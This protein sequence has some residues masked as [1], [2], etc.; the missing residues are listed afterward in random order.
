MRV[1]IFHRVVCLDAQKHLVHAA[2]LFLQIVAVVR[3]YQRDAR[4]PGKTDNAAD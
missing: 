1:G 4:F 2:V 3:R